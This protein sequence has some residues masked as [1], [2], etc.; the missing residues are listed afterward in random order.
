[1]MMPKRSKYRKQQRGKIRGNA[2]SCNKVAFGDF[3]LQALEPG[4]I[5]A[6]TLEAGR[7]A[8]S[9][10][11]PE[12]KIWIRVF[13][14]KPVS[15]KPAETRQGVGKGDIDYWAAIVK[16]GTIMFEL[17]GVTE[18]IAKKAFCRIAHKMPI[19]VRMIAKRHVS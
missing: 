1:M 3:A 14:H 11:A 9:R 6:K 8:C 12:A 5:A 18:D 7:I 10:S 19:K 15:S 17:G 2:T 16:P 13:P 4:W